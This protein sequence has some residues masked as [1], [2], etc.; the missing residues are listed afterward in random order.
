MW[1]PA[2]EGRRRPVYRAIADAIDEDVQ[3][4]SLRA[5]ARLPPHRDLA[6]HLGVTVTTITRAYAEASRRGLIS[7]HVGRGTFI[8]GQASEEASGEAGPLDLSINILMPDKE[9]ANLEAHLFQRRVLPWTQLLGYAPRRG[10]LRHR[11]AMATWL[12]QLGMAVDPDRLALT[13]GAQHGLAT[14]FSALL[15]PGET[16]L[17]E[18]LTYA[19]ARLIAQ[20]LHLRMRGVAMDVEGLRP[21]A[22]DAAC[23]KTRARVLYCMPRLQNPSSSV[24]SDKR[25]RQIAAVADRHRL[26]VVED[27]VYGFLSPEQTPLAALIPERTVFVTS[28]SKSLFPGMRLGCVVAP[29]PL[30][31]KIVAAIWSTMIMASPIGADLLSGWIEDGTAARIA[32]WKRHEVAA[33]QAMIKRLLVHERYQTHPSSPHAWVFLPPRWTSDAFV[34]HARVRGVILNSSSEFAVGDHQPRAV[35]LCLGPPRTRDGLE[36][37][38]IRVVETLADRAPAA[39][40]GI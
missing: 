1:L 40:V 6:D 3:K 19:G 25:R 26:I 22:L 15:K 18:E 2:L 11:Q 20:Q 10:H 31:D 33:R 36:Q 7:G 17:A 32:E 9:V 34:A 28:L 21:D 35:R 16:I 38:L 14:T 23:R 29:P 37:A 27:D 8:R 12:G 13:A 5:G 24:M 4:G 30:L 39:R